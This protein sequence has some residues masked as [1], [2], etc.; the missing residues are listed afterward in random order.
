M[1][2]WR[3]AQSVGEPGVSTPGHS[4]QGEGFGARRLGAAFITDNAITT[5]KANSRR[6]PSRIAGG[7]R[8]RKILNRLSGSRGSG[9]YRRDPAGRSVIATY[10]VCGCTSKAPETGAIRARFRLSRAG[11]GATNKKR[12]FRFTPLSQSDKSISV[13]APRS[14]SFALRRMRLRT[15]ANRTQHRCLVRVKSESSAIA[16]LSQSETFA[17]LTP[18]ASQPRLAYEERLAQLLTPHS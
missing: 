18:G 4:P 16:S 13:K 6:K 3:K 11:F 1:R 8:Y 14:K 5:I 12:K 7:A 9:G 15:A 10:S 2:S 17:T